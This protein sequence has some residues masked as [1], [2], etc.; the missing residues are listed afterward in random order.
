MMKNNCSGPRFVQSGPQWAQSDSGFIVKSAGRYRIKYVEGEYVLVV[1]VERLGG[2]Y[3]MLIF[4]SEVKHWEPP[5]DK[6][7]LSP[8]RLEEIGENIGAAMR[9]LRTPFELR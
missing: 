9:H 1:P 8:E 7:S 6:E 3:L 5:Y 4:V 2:P